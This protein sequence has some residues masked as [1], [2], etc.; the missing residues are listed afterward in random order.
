MPIFRLPVTK[1]II[2]TEAKNRGV[3]IEF[4]NDMESG[5]LLDRITNFRDE[6]VKAMEESKKEQK[7]GKP[8]EEMTEKEFQKAVDEGEVI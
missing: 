2:T 4:P 7:D 1:I 3:V 8:V 5:E 6:L